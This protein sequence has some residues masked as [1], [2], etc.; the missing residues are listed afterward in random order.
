[1]PRQPE[2]SQEQK[3]LGIQALRSLLERA[4]KFTWHWQ[5]PEDFKDVLS[6]E[7]LGL[8]IELINSRATGEGSLFLL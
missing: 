3:L 6:T 1:M 5:R 8:G 7:I 4:D 2:L